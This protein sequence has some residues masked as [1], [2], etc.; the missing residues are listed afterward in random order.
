[1]RDTGTPLLELKGHTSSVYSVAFTPH[2]ARIVTVAGDRNNPAVAKVWDARTGTELKGEPI[3]LTIANSWISPDGRP[4][5]HPEGNRVELVPLQPD[6]EELSYRLLHT[7]PNS[8]RYREG[9]EA[10]RAAKDAFAARFYLNRLAE[11]GFAVGRTQGAFVH[12]ATL[13]SASPQ[14][15]ELSLKVAALQAWFGQEKEFAATRGRILAF[16]KSPANAATA[17]RAARA[18]SILASTDKAELGAALALAGTAVTLGKSARSLLA[19][20][21]AE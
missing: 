9:Y 14:D 12:L 19:L 15:T 10:A 11:R 21:M 8:G 17:E 5:A 18:C 4:F 16:V 3:P 1:V 7:Q 6:A 20:G 2:G 13:S